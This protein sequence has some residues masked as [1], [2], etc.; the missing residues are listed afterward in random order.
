ML[1]AKN[2]HGINILQIKWIEKR[3][4]RK[5][6]KL[7]GAFNSLL[8]ASELNSTWRSPWFSLFNSPAH[9]LCF[10]RAPSHYLNVSNR[11]RALIIRVLSTVST[12]R[13]KNAI[14]CVTFHHL[15]A[16]SFPEIYPWISVMAELPRKMFKGPA[17]RA[18]ASLKYLPTMA[19]PRSE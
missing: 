14:K 15:Q 3:A 10:A 19:N 7:K 4:Q 8:L 9:N 18:T 11:L 12:K 5:A 13:F 1:L 16:L 2:F 17:E 6:E